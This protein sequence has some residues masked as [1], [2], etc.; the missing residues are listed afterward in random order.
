DAS[1]KIEKVEVP[2]ELDLG[3]DISDLSAIILTVVPAD[4]ATVGQEITRL[5]KASRDA[6]GVSV[7]DKVRVAHTTKG[8]A[9]EL[10][11]LPT[12]KPLIGKRV[13][14][15]DAASRKEIQIEKGETVF[16]IP[17]PEEAELTEESE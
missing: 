7:G 15:L 12:I 11:V 2:T 4:K 6:L 14:T 1:S 8:D 13:L 9:I 16:I 17:V 5:D 10:T 3:P